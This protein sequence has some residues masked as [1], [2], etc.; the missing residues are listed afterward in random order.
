M[1]CVAGAGEKE[2]SKTN[3]DV[4]HVNDQQKV[5]NFCER[6][7]APGYFFL[8]FVETCKEMVCEE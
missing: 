8:S 6:D 5:I 4:K 1:S 3:A 2:R 7:A